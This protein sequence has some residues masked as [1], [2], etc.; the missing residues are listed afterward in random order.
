M[1]HSTRRRLL[2]IASASLAGAVALAFAPGCDTAPATGSVN[3]G[4]KEGRAKIQPG[5]PTP[6]PSGSPAAAKPKPKGGEAVHSIKD[7]PGAGQ[8]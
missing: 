2:R 8:P 7:R 6:P 5:A 3:M 1:T 4:G